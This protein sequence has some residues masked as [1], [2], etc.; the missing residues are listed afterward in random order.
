[1]IDCFKSIIVEVFDGQ[2][3]VP[4]Q[5]QVSIP[6]QCINNDVNIVEFTPVRTRMLRIVFTRDEAQNHFVGLTE[7][8]VWAAWPLSNDGSYEAEDGWLNDVNIR[9]SASASGGSYVGQIDDEFAFVEFTGVWVETS[10]YYNIQ[11][12]Y[13]NGGQ[14]DATM[15][16]RIN[17]I[18]RYVATFPDTGHWGYFSQQ[19]YITLEVYLLRGN[20]VLVFQHRT[21]FVELDK[22]SIVRNDDIQPTPS[23]SQRVDFKVLLNMFAF[24]YTFTRLMWN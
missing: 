16:V 12:Y 21:N 9:E 14:L 5:N 10:A 23:G 19:N 17:N 7:M 1:M 11:V 22:I 8:E 15:S 18:H 20:N 2:N 13:S 4:V 6:L 3:W 24:V